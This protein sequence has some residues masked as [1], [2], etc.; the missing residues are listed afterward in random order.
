MGKCTRM[1]S[2]IPIC[3]TQYQPAKQNGILSLRHILQAIRITRLLLNFCIPRRWHNLRR[4]FPIN[5][6]NCLIFYIR[7]S[8]SNYIGWI[9]KDWYSRLK[10]CIRIQIMLMIQWLRESLTSARWTEIYRSNV[11]RRLNFLK[12]SNKNRK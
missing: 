11:T 7:K 10:L 3:R 9:R 6:S 12:I 4:R 1:F 2:H 5:P 8:I